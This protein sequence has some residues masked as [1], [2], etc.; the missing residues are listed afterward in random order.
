M[1]FGGKP[2]PCKPIWRTGRM[3]GTEMR[4]R[5]FRRGIRRGETGSRGTGNRKESGRAGRTDRKNS[6]RPPSLA[7]RYREPV[8]AHIGGKDCGEM[9][10]ESSPNPSSQ[11]PPPGPPFFLFKGVLLPSLFSSSRPSCPSPASFSSFFF[12]TIFGAKILP[13]SSLSFVTRVLR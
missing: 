1:I 3:N 12:N 7:K 5:R 11:R 2:A 10:R 13:N 9:K 8:F 6:G 4:I